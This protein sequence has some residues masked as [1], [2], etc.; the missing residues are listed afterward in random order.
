VMGQIEDV[1]EQVVELRYD[2]RSDLLEGSAVIQRRV[3]DVLNL[4]RVLARAERHT[5]VGVADGGR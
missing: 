5:N 4:K 1:V 2:R 3:A